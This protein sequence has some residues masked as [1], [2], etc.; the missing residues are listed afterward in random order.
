MLTKV[1]LCSMALLKIGEQPIQSLN[2]NTTNAKLGRML[3][4]SITDVLLCAYPW[5]F[6]TKT[7]TLTKNSDGDFIIPGDILRIIKT[8]GTIQGKKILADS[9]NI[10]VQ[11]VV[12]VQPSD[13]PTFFASLV[14][15][16]LAMEFCMPLLSDQTLFRTLASL[17]ETELQNAKFI[18]STMSAQNNIESF[19]LINTRF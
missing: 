17:Y 3:I 15:T 5:R 4:D 11:A 19:N 2:E 1:D 9:E 6:A 13:Y 12:R 8:K 7:Y 14:A 16:R 10:T 18:D